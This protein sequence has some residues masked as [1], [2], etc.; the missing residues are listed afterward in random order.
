MQEL[1]GSIIRFYIVSFVLEE[2]VDGETLFYMNDMDLLKPF[3]LSY[4]NQIMFLKEREKLFSSK[5]IE[6]KPKSSSTSNDVTLSIIAE[7]ESECENEVIEFENELNQSSLN[8]T[9]S[10]TTVSAKYLEEEKSIP[11]PY[12]LPTLPNQVNDAITLKQMDKFEKLCNFR[13]IVIDTVY[14]DL[15]TKYNLM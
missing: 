12:L 10:I 5:T 11:N 8:R 9:S 13:S 6:E 2:Q 4:K 15:K 3:K 1:R 7:G 14:H